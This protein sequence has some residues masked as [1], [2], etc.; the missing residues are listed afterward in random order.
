MILSKL[1]FAKK[2]I[3]PYMT[4]AEILIIE[5]LL[6]T[7]QP[8]R[9]LEWGAGYSTIWFSKLLPRGAEWISVEHDRKWCQTMSALLQAAPL[10]QRQIPH[11]W[12]TLYLRAQLSSAGLGV[13]DPVIRIFGS[14][15]YADLPIRLFHIPPN[16]STPSDVYED[17]TY[18]DFEDY[19]EFP[20]RFGQFDFILVDGRARADC[21]VK[22]YQ[23]VK[24]EGAVVLH[25][26]ARRYYH[27]PFSLY[28]HQVLLAGN[29]V[30]DPN[31]PA[32]G[33]WIGSKKE[34][35]PIAG[36]A[37]EFLRQS[38]GKSPGA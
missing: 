31:A 8:V 11:G 38:S 16:H 27:K 37:N 17:G 14:R 9:C 30:D 12:E 4:D 29:L 36:T 3:K 7:L 33:L 10:S 2:I 35:V 18:A 23:L 22:A 32:G 15:P 24:D 28:P 19:I 5:D 34:I 6:Q 1:L 26:A 25:D 13:I 21:L 20:E